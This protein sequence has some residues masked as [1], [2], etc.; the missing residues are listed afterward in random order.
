MR[1]EKGN[2]RED[3]GNGTSQ[4]EAVVQ[5]RENSSKETKKNP[6]REV[7]EHLT[8]WDQQGKVT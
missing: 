5:M 3:E 6:D 1:D 4:K 7:N 8:L 2:I